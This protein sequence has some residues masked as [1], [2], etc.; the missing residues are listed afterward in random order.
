MSSE[1]QHTP[2]YRVDLVF[3]HGNFPIGTQFEK[4]DGFTPERQPS[5]IG[6][7]VDMGNLLL[8]SIKP[9]QA[10]NSTTN[11]IAEANLTHRLIVQE[12]PSESIKCDYRTH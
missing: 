7:L 8:F 2:I 10:R 9:L 5:G 3:I 1:T 12:Y 6:K 11:P 4:M